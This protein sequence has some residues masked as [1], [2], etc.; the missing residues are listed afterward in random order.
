MLTLQVI[1]LQVS[2]YAAFW[3]CREK[4]SYLH[5]GG[6]NFSNKIMKFIL[7][8]YH[9]LKLDILTQYPVLNHVTHLN[10]KEIDILKINHIYL[11]L[12]CHTVIMPILGLE[13]YFGC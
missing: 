12:I 8:K 10:L 4:N 6:I 2:R 13:V 5:F 3:L 9:I 11:L 7:V 1:T